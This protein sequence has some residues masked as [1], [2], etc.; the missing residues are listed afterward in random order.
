MGDDTNAY[1][2]WLPVS[3]YG[4]HTDIGGSAV[5]DDAAQTFRFNKSAA[6]TSLSFQASKLLSTGEGGALLTNSEELATKAREFSSLGYRMSAT[7]ARIDSATLKAPDFT[8]HYQ[9]GFNYRMNDCTA[10]LGLKQLAN[11]DVLKQIRLECAAMYREAIQGCEWV[12]PQFVP[13]GSHH[14]YWCYAMACDTP[15]R[16]LALQADVVKHGGEMPYGAWRLSYQEPAFKHPVFDQTIFGT[17]L[18]G[19]CPNAESLQPR[20]LQMQ[21][22]CLESAQRNAR[23][24]RK[25]LS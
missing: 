2:A 24:L 15:E 11:I 10:A 25:A 22:N 17:P 23:A 16:A 9:V 19:H 13:A 14:D 20:L 12:K 7:Q 3:L 6:F 1:D 18:V 4:L 5:I 8:R 21:T